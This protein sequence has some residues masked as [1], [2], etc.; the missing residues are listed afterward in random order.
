MKW[1]PVDWVAFILASGLSLTIIL[2]LIVSAIQI[3]EGRIPQVELSENATQI[4]IAGTGGLTGL[5]GAYIGT[6]RNPKDR[7]D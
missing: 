7:D 1:R 3:L 2:I 5:L 4:M 6:Q